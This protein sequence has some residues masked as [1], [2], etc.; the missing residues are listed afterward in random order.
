MDTGNTDR[1]TPP[2]H[3]HTRTQCHADKHKPNR[4]TVRTCKS[5]MRFL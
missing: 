2:P 5:R 4:I 1:N 3:T